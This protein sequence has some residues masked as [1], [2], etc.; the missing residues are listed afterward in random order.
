M[1]ILAVCGLGMGT[2]LILRMNI[3]EVLAAEGVSAEV[4]HSD[5]S[6]ANGEK[7]DYIVTTRE[8]AGSLTNPQGEIIILDNFIDKDEIRKVL[9][10][11]KIV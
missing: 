1:K 3:E 9:K 6:S 2:S 7:C 10:E 8:I 11:N 4:E 5:A